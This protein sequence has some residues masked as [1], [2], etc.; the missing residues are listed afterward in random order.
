[1]CPS[2][3]LDMV[4]NLE[5][6]HLST[7]VISCKPL[8]HCLRCEYLKALLRLTLTCR[9]SAGYQNGIHVDKSFPQYHLNFNQNPLGENET[10]ANPTRI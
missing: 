6:A 2:Q 9:C 1:M 7:E 4:V 5:K 3:Q 10:S 8:S